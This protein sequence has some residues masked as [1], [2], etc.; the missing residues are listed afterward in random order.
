VNP[1]CYEVYAVRYARANKNRPNNFV[2]GDPHDTP[3]PLDYFVWL[4][5][6]EGRCVLV[7]T[8][9][10][11]DSGRRRDRELLECPIERVCASFGLTPHD[12]SDVILTHL[13][14][15]HAGNLDKLPS[16]VFHVQDDE[17]SFATGRCMCHGVIR[18]A[19]DVEDVVTLVRRLSEDRVAFHDGD[20]F[21]LFSG[22]QLLKI[23]GHTRGLQ[24]VR[25]H[26]ERGWVVLASDASHFYENMESS[27]P[28]PILIDMEEVLAGFAR[29]RE[30]A[31]SDQHIVPG[32]DP[33]VLTRYPAVQGNSDIVALHRPP[34]G[35]ASV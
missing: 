18:H 26:T 9:F 35:T 20:E 27:R 5:R 30:Y 12:I 29:L 13:H 14:Y 21:S 2:G 23:G 25:V 19:Y 22:I 10:N 3:M 15:D 11:A 33:L 32:H 16:S 31:D 34:F 7:D 28:F 24:A 1:P 6:G 8:G 4:I 17:V